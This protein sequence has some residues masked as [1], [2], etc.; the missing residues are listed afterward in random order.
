[1]RKMLLTAFAAL[2]SMQAASAS[3]QFLPPLKKFCLEVDPPSEEW[4]YGASDSHYEIFPK[5]ETSTGE[6]SQKAFSIRYSDT[7]KV[8]YFFDSG[9]S[10][11]WLGFE[12]HQV[13]ADGN[14]V[15]SAGYNERLNGNDRAPGALS[16]A[17]LDELKSARNVEIRVTLS[18][19]GKPDKSLGYI[20][21]NPGMLKYLEPVARGRMERLRERKKAGRCV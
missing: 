20:S 9:Q 16:S 6:I 1:M 19:F 21:F 18:S 13:Y 3:A 4:R 11:V 14:L 10:N 15:L 7:G 8:R 17:M 2:V 12:N 5:L